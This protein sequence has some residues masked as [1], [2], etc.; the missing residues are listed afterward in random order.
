MAFGLEIADRNDVP[1]YLTSSRIARSLYEKFGFEVKEAIE[2]DLSVYG[3]TGTDV[4][5]V[6]IRARKGVS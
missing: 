5:C 2:F 3:G 1:V 6:M 4:G